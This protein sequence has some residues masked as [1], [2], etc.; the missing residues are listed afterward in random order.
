M[1]Y[2]DS[3]GEC[4]LSHAGLEGNACWNKVEL[5]RGL[6]YVWKVDGDE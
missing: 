1:E 6:D 5:E 2:V 4:I 3:N